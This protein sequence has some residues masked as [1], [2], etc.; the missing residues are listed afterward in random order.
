[1]ISSPVIIRKILE[2]HCADIILLKI[3]QNNIR[4]IIFENFSV[5]DSSIID[6]YLCKLS[7][8][9]HN[10][11]TKS[12]VQWVLQNSKYITDDKKNLYIYLNYTN[13]V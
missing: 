12:I 2:N 3:H 13:I 1:M 4:I 8:I 5:A 9:G 7:F 11:K 6:N 10:I